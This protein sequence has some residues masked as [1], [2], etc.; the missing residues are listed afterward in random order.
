MKT[1]HTD[2]KLCD[3]QMKNYV[4]IHNCI[5]NNWIFNILGKPMVLEICKSGNERNYRWQG[6]FC[7]VKQLNI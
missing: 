4:E 6:N 7:G 1:R 5:E 3:T 2:E